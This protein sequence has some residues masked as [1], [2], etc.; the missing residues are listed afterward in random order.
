MA[1]RRMLLLFHRQF[2]QILREAVHRI[3]C[4]GVKDKTKKKYKITESNV[5]FNC[6]NNVRIIQSYEFGHF[7]RMLCFLLL[8]RS[9]HPRPPRPFPHFRHTECRTEVS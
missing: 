5:L 6:H 4:A 9:L 3:L 1:I 2:V 7:Q 8:F